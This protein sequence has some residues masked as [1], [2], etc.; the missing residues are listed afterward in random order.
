MPSARQEATADARRMAKY[1]SDPSTIRAH[2]MNGWGVAPPIERIRAMQDE[3]RNLRRDYTRT[4]E[5]PCRDDGEV[6][7]L[8]TLPL[9]KPVEVEPTPQ[10]KPIA[11]ALPVGL[12]VAAK[13]E[14]TRYFSVRALIDSVADDFGISHGELIGSA[15]TR[16]FVNARAVVIQILHRRGWSYSR[17]ARAV[18]RNDHTTMIHSVKTFEKRAE[19]NAEVA[20]CFEAHRAAGWCK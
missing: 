12:P 18:G 10:P 5:K 17:I 20:E 19:Y 3:Y 16:L 11:F 8:G 7:R 9:K 2:C 13:A 1:I 4:I 14:P 6:K 15:R